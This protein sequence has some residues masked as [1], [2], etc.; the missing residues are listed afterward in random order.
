M[1]EA[2]KALEGPERLIGSRVLDFELKAILGAGGM[3]VVYRGEHRVTGQEVAIKILPP[4]LAVHEELKARFVEEARVLAKLEHPNIVRLNN[5]T[6]GGRAALPGHAVRRRRD[7]RAHD[8]R[9]RQG[10]ARRGGRASASRCCKALE[11]AHG[12]GVI[13]RDIKPSNVLVRPDGAV[14]VTDFG[15]AKMLGN[16]RLTSTGQTMGTVRY[17][18]PEQVRGKAVDARSDIYS[19][20]ITLY[21][22]LC[23]RHAVRRREP[24][25]HHAAASAQAAA[26]AGQAAASTLPSALEKV[27]RARSRRTPANRFAD[28]PGL[29]AGAR[30]RVA[31]AAAGGMMRRSRRRRRR[32]ERAGV[33]WRRRS[34]WWCSSPGWRE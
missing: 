18:S 24:L 17:M 30:G 27:L 3:S 8:R 25:R 28:A 11:Y 10:R 9:A 4:E 12:Q 20:G 31:V 34:G 32:R 16:T 13:H 15:I 22:A 14:K 7:L 33:A 21:E 6:R 29:R 1:S 5:F 23:G 26:A 19:L 2:G